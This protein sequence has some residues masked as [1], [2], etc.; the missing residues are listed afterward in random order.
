MLTNL[1]IGGVRGVYDE[2]D[3]RIR[4]RIADVTGIELQHAVN[5]KIAAEAVNENR[6]PET[7]ELIED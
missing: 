5:R 4:Y 6:D 2:D 7:G 3:L 1:M